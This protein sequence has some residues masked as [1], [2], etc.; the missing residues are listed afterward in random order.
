MKL[1]SARISTDHSNV[2]VESVTNETVQNVKILMSAPKMS[3][4]VQQTRTAAIH[5]E[6]SR[7]HVRKGIMKR[8]KN[9]SRMKTIVRQALTTVET[10]LF[11]ITQW[12]RS[13]VYAIL[14]T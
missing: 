2:F 10:V 7:A 14:V 6:A 3:T 8:M 4:I 11:A 12:G 13:S 9:A 1:K 5:Q